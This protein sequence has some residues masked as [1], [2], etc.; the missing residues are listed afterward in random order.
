MTEFSNDVFAE[1]SEWVK[2]YG[3]ERDA[4][5]VAIAK[6]QELSA[7]IIA[8][9]RCPDCFGDIADLEISVGNVHRFYYECRYCGAKWLYFGKKVKDTEIA[10]WRA[11]VKAPR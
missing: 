8:Q 7:W 1:L 4:L 2:T 5:N 6:I 3:N 9:G 11:S 10:K